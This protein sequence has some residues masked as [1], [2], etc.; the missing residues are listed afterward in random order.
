MTTA[1]PCSDTWRRRVSAYQDGGVLGPERLSVEAHLHTCQVCQALIVDYDKLFRDLRSLPSFEGVLTIT[2]PGSRRGFGATS[3][4]SLTWPGKSLSGLSHRNGQRPSGGTIIVTLLLLM[5]L[6]FVF[7]HEYATI[8]PSAA[9]NTTTRSSTLHPTPVASPTFSALTPAGLPCANAGASAALPYAYADNTGAIWSVM[10]CADSVKQMTLPFTDFDIGAWSPDNTQ[11]TILTPA[12]VHRTAGVRTHLY[13]AL[14]AS[15]SITEVNLIPTGTTTPLSADEAFW[16]SNTTLIV[17]AQTKVLQVNPTTH[18][19]T[20][21]GFAATHI[22]WRADALFYSS[23]SQEQTTLHRYDPITK[24]NTSLLALGAG[25]STCT[26]SHCWTS[27]PWDVSQDGLTVAY[28][29]PTALAIPTVTTGSVAAT[30]VLQDFK[31]NTRTTLA[32]MPITSAT[33]TINISPNGHDVAVLATDP[34]QSTIPLIIA[35]SDGKSSH[36]FEQQGACAWRP[37]DQALL[38]MPSFPTAT[39]KAVLITLATDNVT[40][41]PTLTADYVWKN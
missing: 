3:R 20:A 23:V 14:P 18:V 38:V 12:A 40:S 5:G 28:Q 16:T 26:T 30:L 37:D 22:E 11:L 17:R 34:T 25:Q 1:S 24:Q 6:L 41:L 27:A 9:P 33:E 32:P 13:L 39:N 8:G 4:P 19:V 29:Y 35:S 7:G 15:S 21:L 2:K 10:R 36:T 31:T